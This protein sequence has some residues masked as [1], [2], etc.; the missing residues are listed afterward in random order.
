MALTRSDWF[1]QLDRASH[2]LSVLADDDVGTQFLDRRFQGPGADRLTLLALFGQVHAGQKDDYA[3]LLEYGVLPASLDSK[4]FWSQQTSGD[5]FSS[6]INLTGHGMRAYRVEGADLARDTYFELVVGDSVADLCFYWN[7]RA[8]SECTRIHKARVRRLLLMPRRLLHEGDGLRQL[9]EAIRSA[10]GLEGESNLDLAVYCATGEGIDAW[11]A[12]VGDAPEFSRLKGQVSITRSF[13]REPARRVDAER[14]I[15]WGS[16][17]INLPRRFWE[18][19][20]YETPPRVPL[21]TG[22][23]EVRVEPPPSYFKRFAGAQMLDLDSEVWERYPRRTEVAQAIDANACFS[24]YGVTFTSDVS[25]R[26]SEFRFYL[27]SEWETLQAVF[28]RSGLT[29]RQSDKTRYFD[30]LVRL[31]GGFENVDLLASPAAFSLLRELAVPP[32]ERLAQKIVTKLALAPDKQEDI[33]AALAGLEIV[34][35]ISTGS[36][37][38]QQLRNGRLATYKPQ[39][40]PLLAQLSEARIV[41]RG[42]QL[43]CTEC[44]LTTWHP[45]GTADELVECPGCGGRFPLPVEHPADSEVQFHYVLNSLVNQAWDQ[46]AIPALLA[47]RHVAASHKKVYCRIAGLELWRADKPVGDVDFL[48]FADGQLVA[49]EAK[50][51]S[52]LEE[53]DFRGAKLAEEVG[54]TEYSFCTTTAFSSEALLGVDELRTRLAARGSTIDIRVLQQEQLLDG[55]PRQRSG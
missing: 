2:P 12:A 15:V 47:M 30:A 40:L 5:A 9:A 11:T 37:S 38:L 20:D 50:T 28:R 43:P 27:P 6:P 3:E 49:G 24:R 55:G 53:K 31:L 10:P 21:S 8:V 25:H 36:R 33:A 16:L 14:P 39:L 22:D 44:G 13:G 51:G 34:V 46:G 41:R 26:P 45:L 4:D 18:G 35:E 42:F 23:N 29:I 7:L 52:I 19:V 17:E 48:M 32:I 1:E 54:V